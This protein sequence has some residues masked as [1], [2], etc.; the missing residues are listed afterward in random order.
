MAGAAKLIFDCCYEVHLGANWLVKCDSPH[1]LVIRSTKKP[2]RTN[3]GAEH[4]L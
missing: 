4:L 1:L 3:N 2:S